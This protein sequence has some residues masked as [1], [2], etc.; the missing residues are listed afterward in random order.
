MRLC[1]TQSNF[2]MKS[3]QLQVGVIN[4]LLPLTKILE[5]QDICIIQ[6]RLCKC[7]HLGWWGPRWDKIRDYIPSAPHHD[8]LINYWSS[9][10]RLRACLK[11]MLHINN[12]EDWSKSLLQYNTTTSQWTLQ[13][14]SSWLP[15]HINIVHNQYIVVWAHFEWTTDLLKV[16]GHLHYIFYLW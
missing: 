15:L 2:K 6:L 16:P 13:T 11:R 8:I 3:A 10:D 1:W 12:W 14:F 7:A 4:G 9:F 5:G